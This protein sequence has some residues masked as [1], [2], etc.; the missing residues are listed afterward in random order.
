[1][2]ISLTRSRKWKTNVKED[3]QK[4]I[5]AS[6]KLPIIYILLIGDTG[7]GKS[8][9]IDRYLDDTFSESYNYNRQPLFYNRPVREKYFLYKGKHIKVRKQI[10]GCFSSIIKKWFLPKIG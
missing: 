2:I 7:V 1:M 10:I 8:S 9:L 4:K 5:L 3:T 6:Q